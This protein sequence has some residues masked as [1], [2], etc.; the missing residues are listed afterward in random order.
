MGTRKLYQSEMISE[1]VRLITQGLREVTGISSLT[2]SYANFDRLILVPYKVNV[3]GWPENVDRIYPQKLSA[4]SVRALHDAWTNGTA[5]WI[6]LGAQEY[7]ARLRELNSEG[8]LDP[9][10]RQHH[11]DA[12]GQRQKRKSMEAHGGY[13]DSD[14]ENRDEEESPPAHQKKRIKPSKCHRRKG[15]AS[16]A[17]DAADGG[18]AS[19]KSSSSRENAAKGAR[20]PA[21]GRTGKGKQGKQGKSKAFAIDNGST[22]EF[23]SNDDGYDSD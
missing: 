3:I 17:V 14:G 16:A 10:P 4:E 2:M 12:G 7:R 6:R 1:V 19:K 18:G 21:S 13:D 15:Q 23:S 20:K 11:S 9:K 8:K 5:H 22:S